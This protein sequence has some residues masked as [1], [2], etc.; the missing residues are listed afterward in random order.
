MKFNQR[1]RF[2]YVQFLTTDEARAA[3]SLNNK[4]IDKQH[5]LVA[6]ISD[7]NAKKNR[8]GAASEGRELHV[9]NVDFNAT[10]EDI[11]ELFSEHGT[12]ERV[13]RLRGT[14]GKFTGT[15]FVILSKPEEATAA[16]ALNN[17]PLL[18]RLLRVTLSTDKSAAAKAGGTTVVREGSTAEP[19]DL[20]SPSGEANGRRGSVASTG[21]TG[22]ELNADTAR[23]KHERTIALLNLPDTVNDARIQSL[24][25]HYGPLRK[26]VMKRDRAAAMAEFVNLQDAGKVSL[27]IDCSALGP[28]VRIGEP[29][30]IFAKDKKPANAAAPAAPVPKVAGAPVMRPAQA[31]VSRPGQSGR[32]GGRGGLG[33]K[34]GGG[35]GASK[36]AEDADKMD[37]G[38]D[39]GAK[40]GNAEFRALFEKSREDAAARPNNISA[41]KPTG[42]QGA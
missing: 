28:N 24:L 11:K 38:E 42:D 36:P 37:E 4:V 30:E 12:V 17:K 15:C 32:R 10:D 13:R 40:K 5:R 22:G 18:S 29:S 21:A 3:T 34:R 31:S 9:A 23:T 41:A 8:I 1:R 25:S 19:E 6:V 14:N 35:F 16:V 26:I 20:Q 27:G 7:P 33:F 39:G 2:C